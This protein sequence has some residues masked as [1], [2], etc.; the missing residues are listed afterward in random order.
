MYTPGQ[1][2]SVA[3]QRGKVGSKKK[4][5][6]N[7]NAPPP[8]PPPP[9]QRRAGGNGGGNGNA[10]YS[11]VPRDDGFGQPDPPSKAKGY[12]PGQR[13][14]PI[15]TMG[16][17]NKQ[18]RP[19]FEEE[20]NTKGSNPFDDEPPSRGDR[21]SFKGRAGPEDDIPSRRQNKGA[22][23][24]K[25][26]LAKNA[27][28]SAA[29]KKEREEAWTKIAR[30]FMGR[31]PLTY[32][33]WAHRMALSSA[34]MCFF[35]GVFSVLWANAT[36]YGCK[37]YDN[38]TTNERSI[39]STYLYNQFGTCPTTYETAVG[40]NEDVCCVPTDTASG[41]SV[42]GG[43]TAVGAFYIVYSA[44]LVYMEDVDWGVGWGLWF[45]NDNWWYDRCVSPIGIF[46]I[47]IGIIGLSN[48][49]TSIAG[50]C[51][52]ATG[53]AYLEAMRRKESG[54][55]GR[56]A[57]KKQ[58]FKEEMARQARNEDKEM[59]DELPELSLSTLFTGAVC[60]HAYHRTRKFCVELSVVLSYNP[61]TFLYRIYAED[62][63]AMYFWSLVFV[64]ANVVLFAYTYDHWQSVVAEEKDALVN[65]TLDVECL[66][67]VC[68]VNR[69]AIRYGPFGDSVPLAKSCGACLNMDC[70]LILMPV[71]KSILGK[72]NNMSQAFRDLQDNSDIFNKFLSYSLTRYLP[73]N[74]NIEFHR[75]CGY[76]VALMTFGHVVGHYANLSTSF[77]I[78]ITY[79]AKWGWTGTAFLTGGIILMA[80]F[81]MYTAA[82][83]KIRFTKYEIFYNAHHCFIIFYIML[84]LHG[85]VFWAWGIFPVCLYIYDRYLSS[86]KGATPFMVT[87]VEW[88]SPVLAVYFKPL[89]NRDFRFKEGQY[90][91]L[92]CP[93]IAWNEWHPFTISSTQADMENGPRIHVETGEEVQEV[94]RPN[95]L[96]PD[97][98]WNKYCLLSQNWRDTN[99]NNFID[100]CDTVYHDHISCHIK[101]HG[102]EDTSAHTWTRKFKEHLEALNGSYNQNA[103]PFF[104]KRVDHRGDTM[105]GRLRDDNNLPIIRVDGPHSAPSEH[106]TNYGTVMMVGAGIGLTPVASVVSAIVKYRWKKEISPEIL[107][108]YW[109]VRAGDVDS[110]QWL[111]HLLTELSFEFKKGRE[112]GQ[113]DPKYYC[114]FNIYVTGASKPTGKDG[115]YRMQDLHE[116]APSPL[117]RPKRKLGNDQHRP[118]FSA[119]QLYAMML[120]PT[121]SS[122]DQVEHMQANE[123][124]NRLQDVWVWNGRPNWDGIFHEMKD[125]R[126]HSEIGVCFCGAPQI[127]YD[128]SKMCSK[129]SSPSDDI[130]FTLHKENF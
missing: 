99:P 21:N 71:I 59:E 111:V 61:F 52:I 15:S 34:A 85:P 8:P 122:K 16:K 60:I 113:I 14:R 77:K 107:H 4:K 87:K 82:S 48:F 91:Y 29:E 7:P 35:M 6:Q 44:F 126:Q 78:T 125:Q 109:V 13:G 67:K 104:Y 102:L 53:S 119:D 39:H 11:S 23:A 41:L 51:L 110:F 63:L 129:H 62:K 40:E 124:E 12:E 84:F 69:A 3:G 123:A 105:M 46:H 103:F 58:L 116:T 65:G 96:H 26:H 32:A 45:P 10:T 97:A 54:D 76:T 2:E 17:L 18:N 89:Y 94:P 28:E 56:L 66:E 121:V 72:L 36:N 93:H 38:G 108:M 86:Q 118:L 25:L 37:V 27:A 20:K 73:I 106:F 74:K 127:G 130:L 1:R 79:F 55:G 33:V 112:N 5:G 43:Y 31:R 81:I 92:N 75:M 22:V 64:T 128:L 49:A 115:G 9:S 80:M 47:V 70:A 42:N 98:S 19:M 68:D 90:V 101:V 114:E 83:D 120:H 50:L 24:A 57:K 30:R 117:Y 100:K 95:N 88:I